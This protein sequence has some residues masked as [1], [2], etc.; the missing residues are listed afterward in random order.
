MLSVITISVAWIVKS[1]HLPAPYLPG[2]GLEPP[3]TIVAA[4]IAAGVGI[5]MA[6]TEDGGLWAWGSYRSAQLGYRSDTDYHYPIR[7]MEDMAAV[8]INVSEIMFSRVGNTLV[9]A[10]TSDGTLKIWGV[11]I[12]DRD[13]G[14]PGDSDGPI[15]FGY[16]S[17]PLEVMK[18]VTAFSSGG[19]HLMAITS[20]NTLWGMGV[21]AHGRAGIGSSH[22]A[23]P[24]K[25]MDNVVA[26]S[27]GY[28]HTV[29]VTSDGVL[30]AMGNNSSGQLGVA[31]DLVPQAFNPIRIMDDVI[32]VS[33]GAYNTTAIT[34][35]GTLWG[36]G[37][38][39]YGQ[40]G[41][42]AS[43]SP[44]IPTKIMDDVVAVSA[45]YGHTMFIRSDGTLWGIGWNHF[46][47]LG[48]GTTENRYSPVRIMDDVVYVSASKGHTMAVTSDGTLWAWSRT[49][50]EH[51]YPAR[52]MDGVR[53]P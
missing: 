38:N 17:E 12:R 1:R 30:W 29:A 25:V 47:Q 27:T 53:L 46:G 51:L 31:E 2:A 5:S 13:F 22:S 19:G 3:D 40:L 16:L 32:A 28:R 33:A 37:S 23:E 21:G 35:D 10:L 44:H 26:V 14:R 20:D 36:W 9:A 41:G 6:V 45:G 11:D 42:G 50:E 8:S 49:T 52:V 15:S 24:I 34:S 4:P 43:R 39:W 48:D 18:N 7:I